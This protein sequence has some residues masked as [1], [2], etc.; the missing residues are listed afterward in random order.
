[1]LWIAAMMALVLQTSFLA[2]PFG[3]ALFF[4]KGSAPASVSLGDIYR[5]IV[6]IVAIQ[7][8]VIAL[9]IAFGYHHL[10]AR[11]GL[12]VCPIGLTVVANFWMSQSG[13]R[14]LTFLRQPKPHDLA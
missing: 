13:R 5:G 7:L 8:I 11:A 6:P 12:Q 1:M 9:V 3:F 14:R 10:A 4:L 2:P